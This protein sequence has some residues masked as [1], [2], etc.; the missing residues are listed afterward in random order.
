M[1]SI[2]ITYHLRPPPITEVPTDLNPTKTLS[3]PIKDKSDN[4]RQFYEALHESVRAAKDKLGEDLTI[5][6]DV[7]GNGEAGKETKKTLK[8]DEDEEEE[9]EEEG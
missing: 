8:Y 6:R 1:S 2:T 4:P 7:V 5:W 3:F 9:E